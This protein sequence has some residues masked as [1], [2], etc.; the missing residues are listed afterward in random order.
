MVV[1]G[2]G[3][4][5]GFAQSSDEV[6]PELDEASPVLRVTGVA[7]MGGVNVK[8]RRAA[9]RLRCTS[10]TVSGRRRGTQNPCVARAAR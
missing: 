6:E 2:V 8:R 5:G 3:I 9:A 10:V 1:D 7:L 4:M